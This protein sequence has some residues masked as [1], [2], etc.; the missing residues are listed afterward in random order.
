[1]YH[2][3]ITRF[4]HVL[5]NETTR[6]RSSPL[7]DNARSI[8]GFMSRQMLLRRSES[9]K[10]V[11]HVDEE[12]ISCIQSA[13]DRR[14]SN[15]RAIACAQNWDDKVPQQ[16][17]RVAHQ[18]DGSVLDVHRVLRIGARTVRRCVR[19][20]SASEPLRTDSDSRPR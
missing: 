16:W 20:R 19:K 9:C 8:D 5:G 15:G 10:Q 11:E 6:Q 1:L 18:V 12:D 2:F 17:R 4:C 3:G 13:T 7:K 14:T